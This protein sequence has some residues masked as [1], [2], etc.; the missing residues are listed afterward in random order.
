MFWSR[1]KIK[2]LESRIDYLNLRLE[3]AEFELKNT[4]PFKIGYVKSG[5]YKGM[6]VTDV[7]ICKEYKYAWCSGVNKWKISYVDKAGN[8]H[9]EW[10]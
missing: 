9:T 8:T 4:P 2:E 6:T 3:R 10:V 5:K 7:F 1:K